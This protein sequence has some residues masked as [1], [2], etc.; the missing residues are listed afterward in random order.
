MSRAFVRERDD[1]P[2]DGPPELRLDS[3]ANLVTPRGLR[4][5]EQKLFELNEALG[6]GPGADDKARLLRDL[7][8]WTARR[9]SAQLVDHTA[10]DGE[11]GFGSEIVIRR[12][13]GPPETFHIVGEDEADPAQGRISYVSPIAQALMGARAGEIVEVENRK[14]PLELEVVS[15]R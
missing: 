13:G 4:L 12:H 11:V 1:A 6:A 3:G 14:P 7:R 5:M 15:V 8:Y 9:A 2:A 10:D